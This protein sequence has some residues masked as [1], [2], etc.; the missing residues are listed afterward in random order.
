MT[1]I[2]CSAMGTTDKVANAIAECRRLGLEV[3]LPSVNESDTQFSVGVEDGEQ[4]IRYGLA[5]IKNVGQGAVQPIIDERRQNGPFRSVDDFCQRDHVDGL[6][7]RTM[8]SL[9]KAGAFD[10][11]GRRSQVLHVLD[12]IIGTAQ[13]SQ[14]MAGANQGSLFDLMPDAAEFNAVLLP[15]IPELPMNEILAWEKELL[16][17]YVSEHPVQTAIAS[18]TGTINAHCSRIDSEM[19]GKQVCVAGV[20]NSVRRD[21][22]EE[23]RPDGDSVA[24]RPRR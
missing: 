23:R 15:D 9:I 10:C 24:R 3:Q 21:S 4:F 7:R 13:K 5:A 11:L 16:G 12:R 2:L 1:A 18:L 8:E 19:E 14:Q 6:N 20:V 17:V 22:H